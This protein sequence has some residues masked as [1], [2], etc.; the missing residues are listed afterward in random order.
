MVMAQQECPILPGT[1][2]RSIRAL[3]QPAS[4]HTHLSAPIGA[5]ESAQ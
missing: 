2:T 4:R 1:T 3:N 5:K